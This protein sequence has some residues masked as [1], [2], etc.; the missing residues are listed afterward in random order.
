MTREEAFK[1]LTPDMISHCASNF[2]A[3]SCIDNCQYYSKCKSLDYTHKGA[4]SRMFPL[5]FVKEGK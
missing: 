3:I 1:Q 2:W 5:N 4:P